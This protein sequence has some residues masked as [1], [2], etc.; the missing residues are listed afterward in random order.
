M[1]LYL[2][3]FRCL[4]SYCKNKGNKLCFFYHAAFVGKY[5]TETFTI[6]SCFCELFS[7]SF[8]IWSLYL[9]VKMFQI[10]FNLLLLYFSLTIYGFNI[11]TGSFSGR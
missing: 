9:S 11:K 5:Q 7:P 8:L 3:N 4:L 1:L 10:V 2:L 6:L